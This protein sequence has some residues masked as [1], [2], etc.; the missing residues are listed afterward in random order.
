MAIEIKNR[1]PFHR[2]N[3]P[4]LLR[5]FYRFQV[6]MGNVGAEGGAESGFLALGTE[7]DAAPSVP[8]GVA[9]LVG[10]R[11]QARPDAHARD[12][13]S[14]FHCISLLSVLHKSFL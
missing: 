3:S 13:Y 12:N 5:C 6:G 2:R 9:H 7:D 10:R 1:A 14:L 8:E 11:A 4:A